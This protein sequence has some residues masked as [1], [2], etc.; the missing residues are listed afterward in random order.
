MTESIQVDH[1]RAHRSL[2]SVVSVGRIS[3]REFASLSHLSLQTNR[4]C[5]IQVLDI[6]GKAKHLAFFY[7]F[8][9]IYLFTD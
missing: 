1:R 2:N 5:L 8:I 4:Q 3:L 9:Y 7:L 6:E